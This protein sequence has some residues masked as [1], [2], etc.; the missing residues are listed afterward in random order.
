[1]F[2]RWAYIENHAYVVVCHRYLTESDYNSGIFVLQAVISVKNHTGPIYRPHSFIKLSDVQASELSTYQETMS[3][4][5]P[6]VLCAYAYGMNACGP[7]TRL[8]APPGCL[9]RKHLHG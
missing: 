3:S 9:D 4:L 8:C 6:S 1:M 7:H 5:D 2:C